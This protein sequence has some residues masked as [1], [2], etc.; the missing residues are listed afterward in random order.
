M[1]TAQ[2]RAEVSMNYPP[3]GFT[4]TMRALTAAAQ[5]FVIVSGAGKADALR[6]AIDPASDPKHYPAAA[7][8]SAGGRVVWWADRDA[9]ADSAT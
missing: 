2:V 6:R 1:L 9:A 4:L 5:L 8:Q 3:E 7:L